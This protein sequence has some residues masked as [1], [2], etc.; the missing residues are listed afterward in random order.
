MWSDLSNTT[1]NSKRD[2]K[3]KP[4]LDLFFSVALQTA[5][6]ATFHQ[7]YEPDVSNC[8]EN[9]TMLTKMKNTI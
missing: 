9:H 2:I 1:C 6:S 3:K 4:N 8:L 5:S 7:C